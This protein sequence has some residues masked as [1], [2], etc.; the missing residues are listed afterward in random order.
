MGSAAERFAQGDAPTEAFIAE[1]RERFPVE[2]EV[3]AL[4][5][6]KLRRRKGPPY[7]RISKDELHR[8]LDRM[9]A[10]LDIGDHTIRDVSWFTGGVSKIQLGFW[11]DWSDANGPRSDRMVVRM[12]PSE[13]S[14]MS[15][16]RVFRTSQAVS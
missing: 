5:T 10:D 11:L 1:M 6:R 9:F 7:S 2:A 13:G 15:V 16:V 4:L 12:D 14:N 3:D 8:T